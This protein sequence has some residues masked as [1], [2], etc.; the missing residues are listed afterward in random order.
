M[1]SGAL[2]RKAL[3]ELLQAVLTASGRLTLHLSGAAELSPADLE[4]FTTILK[5]FLDAL[6]D[7]LEG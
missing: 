7:K 3:P 2:I 4:R 5:N 1:K 6:E